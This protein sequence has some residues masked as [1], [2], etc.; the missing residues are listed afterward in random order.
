MVGITISLLLAQ[1]LLT[2]P[3]STAATSS[4]DAV[5]VVEP[6]EP[7]EAFD[8]APGLIEQLRYSELEQ[9]VAE[10]EAKRLQTQLQIEKAKHAIAALQKPAANPGNRVTEQLSSIILVGF[11]EAVDGVKVVLQE[12]GQWL[13]LTPG[14]RGAHDLQVEV[15]EQQVRLKR[16][17]HYRD[18][19]LPQGW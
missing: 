11:I 17:G 16:Y 18:I 15:H 8:P 5:H 19:P 4:V 14:E 9:R 1:Q 12:R 13:L 7:T 2:A 6:A 10:T 3:P